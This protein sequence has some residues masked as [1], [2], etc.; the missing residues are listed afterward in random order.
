MHGRTKI[1]TKLP[2][3]IVGFGVGVGVGVGVGFGEGDGVKGAL[4]LGLS[5]RVLEYN[6]LL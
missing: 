6:A 2:D 3:I 5:G 4:N 1:D